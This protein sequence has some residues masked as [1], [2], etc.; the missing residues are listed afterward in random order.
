[1]KRNLIEDLHYYFEQ[2]EDKTHEEEMFLSHLKEELPYFA[3]T[4]LHRDD[5][6]SRGFDAEE[7]D[8]CTMEE[9]ADKMGN[10]YQ[11]NGYW[12]DLDIIAEDRVEKFKCPK[13][14]GDAGGYYEDRC[15]CGSCNHEWQ[16]TESTGRY[17][18]VEHS[19]SSFFEKHEV[20]FES[21]QSDDN[22]ARY[23]PEHLYIAHFD[24]NP[25]AKQIYLPIGWPESQIYL[26]WEHTAPKK[27]ARCEYINPADTVLDLGNDALFVPN[28]LIK[29]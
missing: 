24:K 23:I 12:I 10:A 14:W 3:I 4:H 16:I 15:H 27:F 17:V 21:Y 7:V 26:E 19:E 28:S 1:M 9:I 25:K 5:L 2:K 8:D 29:R 18:L 11:E 20:G 13:C 6:A 22:G